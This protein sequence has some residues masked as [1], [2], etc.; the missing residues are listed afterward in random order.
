MKKYA[1]VILFA[2]MVY[3]AK[4]FI[5]QTYTLSNKMA[6]SKKNLVRKIA[7]RKNSVIYQTNKEN[8]NDIEKESI[9]DDIFAGIPQ[10][11][12]FSKNYCKNYFNV[13][14]SKQYIC[15]QIE[16]ECNDEWDRYLKSDENA[17]IYCGE[18]ASIECISEM[19]QMK[20]E[21]YED[22]II[23]CI[24][25]KLNEDTSSYEDI[26]N[27]ES[28]IL[29]N[30]KLFCK[31]YLYEKD[32]ALCQGVFKFC[33]SAPIEDMQDTLRKIESEEDAVESVV[34]CIN[35]QMD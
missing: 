30:G 18:E 33:V 22:N 35:E 2:C 29:T 5:S 27:K 16:K 20:D 25:N 13:E 31:K 17:L 21:A 32:S 24:E 8:K 28:F 12:V 3:I 14:E 11:K 9:D 19:A 1:F 23:N 10:P 26:L 4:T 7:S 6:S 15:D 34:D